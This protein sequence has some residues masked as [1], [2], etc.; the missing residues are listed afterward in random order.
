MSTNETQAWGSRWGFIISAIGMT[1]GTGAM[2]RFPRVAAMYGGMPFMIALVI[3]LIMWSIPLLMFEAYLGKTT[4]AGHITSIIKTIGKK[5]TWLGTCYAWISVFLT[6]YYV[7]VF[8]WTI[9]YLAYAI[10]G[11]INTGTDT[12][13]LWNQFSTG[14]GNMVVWWLIGLLACVGILYKGDISGV[15]KFSK[16]VMPLWFV[17]IVALMLRAITLPNGIAGIRYLFADDWAAFKNPTM[18]LEAFT[19]CVWQSAPGLGLMQ[20][21]AIYTSKDEDI[22]LNCTLIPFSVTS[23]ALLSGMTVIPTIFAL[24]PDPMGAI[25]SG[26]TGMTFI[27]LTKLFTVIK[28]GRYI[29]I[30][31]FLALVIAA[32]TSAIAQVE[33]AVRIIQDAVHE[34]KKAIIYA[35]MVLLVLGLPS[36]LDINFLN[37]QDWVW[38]V[39]VLISGAILAVVAIKI[40]LAKIWDEGIGPCSDLNIPYIFKNIYL[41]PFLFVAI[42]GMWAYS[43][44]QSSPGEWM[45]WLPVSKYTYS[46]GTMLYQW[47]FMFVVAF[48]SNG[49]VAKIMSKPSTF[50]EHAQ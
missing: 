33:L 43:T 1:I 4:R 37:N 25:A 15:E 3:A 9:R 40:G 28:G 30:M 12:E 16:F 20:C 8:G 38:G 36:A 29:S 22:S 32:Y 47:A 21:Y 18:W 7:V 44:I 41:I 31:F 13:F 24:S 46:F 19:Q 34:R 39:G 11:T 10:M 6:A 42:M 49:L 23:A 35:G 5:F 2:W 17:L 14:S 26:N 48:A 50:S 27:H 45:R